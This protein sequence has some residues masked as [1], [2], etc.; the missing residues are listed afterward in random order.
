MSNFKILT[1]SLFLLTNSILTVW[2]ESLL[3]ATHTRVPLESI[4][5]N[6][7]VTIS[8]MESGIMDTLF[9]AGHVFFNIYNQ[10]G[11]DG[12]GMTT[13]DLISMSGRLDSDYLLELIPDESGTVW[14]LYRTNNSKQLIENHENISQISDSYNFE[15][16]WYALGQIL[17]RAVT[18]AITVH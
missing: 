8:S 17:G 10:P 3:I 12:E 7:W 15:K 9:D 18:D 11:A 4:N 2:S 14:N 13:E 5:K 1:L 16:R 6:E